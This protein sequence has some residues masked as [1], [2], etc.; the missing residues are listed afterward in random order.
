MPVIHYFQRWNPATYVYDTRQQ[1]RRCTLRKPRIAVIAAELL[2]VSTIICSATFAQIGKE[3]SSEPLRIA[4]FADSVA[5]RG[6][7]LFLR[8]KDGTVVS[9]KNAPREEEGINDSTAEPPKRYEFKDFIDPWYT[10]NALESEAASTDFINRDTGATINVEGFSTFTPDKAHFIARGS[11]DFSDCYDEIWRLSRA[12]AVKEW[13]CGCSSSFRWLD[14]NTAEFG[15]HYGGTA[16]LKRKGTSWKCSGDPDICKLGKGAPPFDD[17]DNA[18]DACKSATPLMKAAAKG[19][20]ADV[21]RLLDSG[22][23][24][25]GKVESCRTALDEA[26]RGGHSDVVKLLLDKGAIIS[27][28]GYW[29]TLKWASGNRKWDVVKVLLDR[30]VDL[31]SVHA[32]FGPTAL[33]KAASDGN[34]GLIQTLLTK[35][36]VLDAEH[37]CRALEGAAGEG[38]PEIVKFLL[39]KGA[40]INAGNEYDRTALMSAAI[41][42]QVEIVR[43]LLDRGADVNAKDLRDNTALIDAAWGGNPAVLKLLLGK[44]ADVNAKNVHGETALKI[45]YGDEIRKLLLEHGAKE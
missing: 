33:V 14:S 35:G 44:A 10:V 8:L 30:G 12:G 23:D 34:L 40:D 16:R 26:A 21:K 32:P 31:N 41:R 25:N 39:E 28:E 20:L 36:V 27:T 43:L 15:E 45:A 17:D 18:N 2:I 6:G 9:R 7:E 24:V 38:H 42:G 11:P 13:Q 1:E 37:G 22:A 3:N 4:P 5:R 29:P 19:R